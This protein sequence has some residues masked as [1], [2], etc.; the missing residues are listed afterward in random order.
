ML[1]YLVDERLTIQ[2]LL[3]LFSPGDQGEIVLGV[4]SVERDL[5]QNGSDGL[6]P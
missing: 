5:Y 3:V 2:Q 1:A 6:F 4:Y